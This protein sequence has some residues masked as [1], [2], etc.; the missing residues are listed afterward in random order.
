MMTRPPAPASSALP[1][2]GSWSIRLFKYFGEHAFVPSGVWPPAFTSSTERCDAALERLAKE[3]FG[4]GDIAPAAKTEVHGLA[5]TINRPVFHQVT[6]A[7]L[8]DL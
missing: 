6:V 5:L 7:E 3:C 1:G 8:A 2:G 4:R